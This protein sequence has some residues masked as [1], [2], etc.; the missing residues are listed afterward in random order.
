MWVALGRI[1]CHK[2]TSHPPIVT[3]V[4]RPRSLPDIETELLSLGGVNR[5]GREADRLT[6]FG[7]GAKIPLLYLYSDGAV[8]TVLN[9]SGYYMYHGV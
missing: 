3:C 4:R 9:P 6:P 1:G 7:D 2:V 5:P 8:L